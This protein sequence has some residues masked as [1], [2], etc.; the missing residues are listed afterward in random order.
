MLLGGLIPE[1]HV[2]LLYFS[3]ILFVT[4]GFLPILV[5]D[6][7]YFDARLTAASSTEICHYIFLIDY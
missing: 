2:T 6:A 1:R 4:V 3:L 5:Y 7:V